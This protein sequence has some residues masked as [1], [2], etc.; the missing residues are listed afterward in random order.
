MEE[1]VIQTAVLAGKKR[2]YHYQPL[3]LNYLEDV[4]LRNRVKFSDPQKFNDPWDCKPTFSKS[5]LDDPSVYKRYVDYAIDLQRRHFGID[6]A[7]L[8]ERRKALNSD[9]ELMETCIDELSAAM[10]EAIFKDYRV[11]CMAT[12]PDN[13]LMWAHYSRSHS[14]IC[15]GFDTHSELFC[16]ALRVSYLESYPMIDFSSEDEMKLLHD[17]LLVKGKHWSYEEEF[18]VIAKEGMT[19]E[20]ISLRNGFVDFIPETLTSITLGCYVDEKNI[21]AIQEILAQSGTRPSLFQVR[22]K[23]DEFRF[24]RRR[25]N[26]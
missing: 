26:Y 1:E 14:G 20:F 10:H 8:L 22:P 19:E 3:R 6:E 21:D 12:R 7:E 9:R 4:L 11:Y 16:G 5:I 13:F 23:P 2:L 18:R 25:L 15:L 17:T 24:I